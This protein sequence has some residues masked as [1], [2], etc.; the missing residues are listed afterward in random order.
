MKAR[1]IRIEDGQDG[2]NEGMKRR[3]R[4]KCKGDKIMEM[5]VGAEVDRCLGWG[6][7]LM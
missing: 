6:G 2:E 3:I 7:Q 5:K 1:N 4:S